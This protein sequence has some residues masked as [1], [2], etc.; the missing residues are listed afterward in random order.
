MDGTNLYYSLPAVAQYAL[1]VLHILLSELVLNV[2]T[3]TRY[4]D[5]VQHIQAAAEAT[6]LS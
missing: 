5:T 1:L 3:Q 4:G 2:Y 6:T